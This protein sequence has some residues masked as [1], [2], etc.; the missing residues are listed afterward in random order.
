MCLALGYAK[1]AAEKICAAEIR[2]QK[3][4]VKSYLYNFLN[5]SESIKQTEIIF[6]WLHFGSPKCALLTCCFI[7]DF[8]F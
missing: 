5:Q 6:Q 1:Y 4:P 7:L 3:N 8:L 2:S